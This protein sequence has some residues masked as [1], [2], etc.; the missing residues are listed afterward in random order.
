MLLTNLHIAYCL[1]SAPLQIPSPR[2]LTAGCDN[3]S[4]TICTE[5]ELQ[6]LS[7]QQHVGAMVVVGAEAVVPGCQC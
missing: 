4:L 3:G 2:Y 5:G 6:A 1:N 7:A